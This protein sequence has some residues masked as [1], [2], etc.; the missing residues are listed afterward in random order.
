MNF[1]IENPFTE[2]EIPTD[3]LIQQRI[4]VF[5]RKEKREKNEE[6]LNIRIKSNKFIGNKNFCQKAFIFNISF[7]ENP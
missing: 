2:E 5:N 3:E 4:D 7:F 1:E 6:F